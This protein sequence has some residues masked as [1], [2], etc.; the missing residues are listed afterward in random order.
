MDGDENRDYSPDEPG[1][2]AGGRVIA[3]TLTPTVIRDT[4]AL[5]RYYSPILGV[6]RMGALVM[7]LYPGLLQLW[8]CGRRAGRDDQ[9]V[10]A[11]RA[12]GEARDRRCC[13]PEGLGGPVEMVRRASSAAERGSL[14]GRGSWACSISLAS[15]TS[16]SLCSTA[17]SFLCSQASRATTLAGVREKA[18][19]IGVLFILLMM[20]VLFFDHAGSSSEYCPRHRHGRPSGR[21]GAGRTGL[22]ALG[23]NGR[24]WCDAVLIPNSPTAGRSASP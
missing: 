15:S 9:L 23:A 24:P 1:S 18:Q 11:A 17:G 16:Q 13:G 7:A 12:G 19:Q 10:A 2:G 21:C 8:R 20:S 4:N 14:C 6:T 5:G 3:I 22:G